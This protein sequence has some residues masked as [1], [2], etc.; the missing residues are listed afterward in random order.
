MGF[1]RRRVSFGD[2]RL[3]ER[4]WAKVRVDDS[5]CW[6]WTAGQKGSGYGGFNIDQKWRL[7]HRVSYYYLVDQYTDTSLVVDH[8]CRTKLCVNPAHLDAVTA[9]QNM[10]RYHQRITCVECGKKVRS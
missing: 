4:F 5:G 10:A 1:K 3:P 6:L 9:K 8:L 7:A 2:V